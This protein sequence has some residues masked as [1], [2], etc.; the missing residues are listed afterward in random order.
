M[1]VSSLWAGG[2]I[3]WPG[4]A[5]TWAAWWLGDILGNL[6]IAPLL[7]T[8]WGAWRLKELQFA[9]VVEG[10][11]LALTAVAVGW[12]IFGGLLT[13]E[14]GNSPIAYLIFPPIIWAALRFGQRGTVTAT[15]GMSILAIWGTAAGFGPF[16][17]E[18]LSESLFFLQIFMGVVSVT[19]LILAAVV[20]ERQRSEE[21]LLK[22]RKQLEQYSRDLQEA[23]EILKK[24]SESKSNFI[25]LAAHELITP[26]TSIGGFLAVILQG[27][28]GA[29]TDKQ[30]EYLTLIKEVSDQ[31]LEVVND[32]LDITR[33]ELGQIK[34]K[35]ERTEL[36][37]LLDEIVMTFKMQ[38]GKK[39][40]ALKEEVEE[41]LKPVVCDPNRIKEVLNNLV[42]NAIKYTPR[43]GKIWIRAKNVPEAVEIDIE[44]TGI[45]IK[46]E[47]YQK[48]FEPFQHIRK[49]GL[50]GEKSAGLG[51]ALVK[52]I[53]EAHGGRIGIQS[54]VGHG[55]TFSVILPEKPGGVP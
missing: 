22:E 52:K 51:L 26:L 44:D 10:G 4:Y 42:S 28:T 3:S 46:K 9:K 23:N 21:A 19:A 53:V 16:V 48:I 35:L 40:I 33:I 27:K 38:V 29:L 49:S 37:N 25:A 14:A 54:Q 18:R 12:L 50:Q 5:P 30:K 36:K 24:L 20:M 32:L 1:G 34:M 2:V 11:A 6:I 13:A 41:P 8:W 15:F 43:K 31:L 39:N 17:R 45:G 47:N 55:S 7:L